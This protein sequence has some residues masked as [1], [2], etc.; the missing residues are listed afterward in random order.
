[1]NS[2]SQLFSRDFEKRPKGIKRQPLYSPRGWGRCVFPLFATNNTTAEG[3]GSGFFVKGLDFGIT[4]EHLVDIEQLDLPLAAPDNLLELD[5]SMLSYG[6]TAILPSQGIVFGTCHIPPEHSQRIKRFI[7]DIVKKD[8]PILELAGKRKFSR[9]SDILFL[10]FFEEAAIPPTEWLPE[11]SS[12]PPQIGDW[13]CAAGYPDI[14]TQCTD[15]TELS[16]LIQNEGM[17]IS[18]ARV[19]Q[20]EQIG[21][22][23]HEIS[24]VVFVDSDWPGGMSGGPVFTEDGRVVGVVSRE[25]VDKESIG[26]RGSFTLLH[27]VLT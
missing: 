4:A 19:T 8:A 1:M 20:V 12:R 25:L 13:V 16:I 17:A 23:Q 7:F 14:Q 24:P 5:L 18:F 22:G 26:N 6:L 15:K 27:P 11:I 9:R 21:R 2:F 10:E 3:L